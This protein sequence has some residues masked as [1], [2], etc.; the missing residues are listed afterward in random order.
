[1]LRVAEVAVHLT[2]QAGLEDPFGQITEQ[3]ARPGRF[4]PLGLGTID[5]LLRELLIHN[6]MIGHW[7]YSPA[8]HRSPS[9]TRFQLHRLSD[10]PTTGKAIQVRS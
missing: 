10:T 8:S 3:A 7:S 5:E 2:F 9:Q 6:C 1:M 4:H